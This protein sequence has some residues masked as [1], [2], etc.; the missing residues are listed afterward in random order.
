MRRAHLPKEVDSKADKCLRQPVEEA[1]GV[2]MVVEPHPKA[3]SSGDA[4]NQPFEQLRAGRVRARARG[5][6]SFRTS[7][8]CRAGIRVGSGLGLLSPLEQLRQERGEERGA[9][10]PPHLFRVVRREAHR[11][12]ELADWHDAKGQHDQRGVVRVPVLILDLSESQRGRED[13]VW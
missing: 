2:D 8:G 12:A 1:E 3:N 7:V 5:V 9:E 6:L 4:R 13:C 10:C 11:A